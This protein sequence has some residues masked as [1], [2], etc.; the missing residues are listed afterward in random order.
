MHGHQ[1]AVCSGCE[2]IARRTASDTGARVGSPEVPDCSAAGVLLNI[3]CPV[4]CA[5]HPGH[6]AS[7][8]FTRTAP[9]PY[10]R[11]SPGLPRVSAR[12]G[13]CPRCRMCTR[14]AANSRPGPTVGEA[15][16]ASAGF[17]V[18]ERTE[19]AEPQSPWT[20]QLTSTWVDDSL[21]LLLAQRIWRKVSGWH[22]W[23]SASSSVS[24]MPCAACAS[25]SQSV[26]TP[27]ALV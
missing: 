5:H 6:R 22:C 12:A 25:I 7:G 15:C 19:S 21:S 17:V 20:R 8:C 1:V 27:D 24:T 11:E 26:D 10:G 18:S 3:R 14:S 2:I 16:P 13:R 9:T 4:V 23:V